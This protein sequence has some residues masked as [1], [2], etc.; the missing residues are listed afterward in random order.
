MIKSDFF[1]QKVNVTIVLKEG[2]DGAGKK[3]STSCFNEN[4]LASRSLWSSIYV[5]EDFPWVQ[6]PQSINQSFGGAKLEEAKFTK[7]IW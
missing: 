2:G 4:E 6:S 7:Q 1:D 3:W 5:E